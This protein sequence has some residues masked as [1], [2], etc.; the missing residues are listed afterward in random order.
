MWEIA[1]DYHTGHQNNHGGDQTL[2]PAKLVE[3][4]HQREQCKSRN[5]RRA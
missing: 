3:N 1:H 4:R 5:H 2:L